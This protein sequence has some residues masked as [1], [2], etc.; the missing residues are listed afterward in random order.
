MKLFTLFLVPF[1]FILNGFS[2]PPLNIAENFDNNNLM[3]DVG[4]SEKADLKIE[5][6]IYTVDHHPAD[7]AGKYYFKNF[8]V[9]D[10][11]DFIIEMNV[12]FVSGNVDNGYGLHWGADGWANSNT[13]VISGNQYYK[14]Q[15][16]E[17]ENRIDDIDW[18][19]DS[20]LIKGKES[21]N[22]IRVEK[23]G[24]Q[25]KI[26]I[27]NTNIGTVKYRPFS[28]SKIG[29]Y[30]SQS[31][32]VE[33]DYLHIYQYGDAKINLVENAINGYQKENLGKSINGEFSDRSPNISSDGKTLYYIKGKYADLKD[34]G[35]DIYVSEQ[36]ENGEW[37]D[38]K[39]LGGPINNEGN[40]SV[41]NVSADGNTLYLLNTYKAD[42]TSNS[43]GLSISKKTENGWEIPKDVII[44]DFYNDSKYVGYS[45]S[46]NRKVMVMSLNR[47]DSYGDEDL[48]VSFMDDSAFSAPLNMGPIIN[49]LNDQSTPFLAPDDKTLYF[50]SNGHPG[51]GS[52]DIFMTR[53]LDDTWTNWSKPENLGPEINS[54]DFDAF[55]TVTA[56]G[57]Y[58]YMVSSSNSFG[59][60]DI[61]KIKVPESAKPTPL[62]L[63]KG[64]VLNSKTKEPIFAEIIYQ[65]LNTGKEVG[66]AL[67]DPATGNYQ[68]VLP[69]GI[70]YG[71]LAEKK[72]FY[73]VSNSADA[74]NIQ[75]YKELNVDLLLTPIEVGENIRLNNLFFETSKSDLKDISISELDRLVLFLKENPAIIIEIGGHTDNVGAAAYNQTLSEKRAQSVMSYLISKEIDAKRL[76]AKGFGLTKPVAPNTND[77]GKAI[78][79]RVEMKILA[80]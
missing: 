43:K 60:E 11:K 30:L 44:D 15:H 55:F 22:L 13:A 51:Y 4:N 10:T 47:K 28:G 7:G 19:K 36:L 27:N 53:R 34:K 33:I 75:E 74:T 18:K 79:R 16:Y 80:K 76:T 69:A 23:T 3:W 21:F 2:Q 45:L 17:G 77:E 38:S 12:R 62:I 6:G 73:P 35:T 8:N 1:L 64:K 67:S 49:T 24:N 61:F 40:N 41:V 71:Y 37:G 29:L 57:D 20:L 68:V 70:N 63:I 25:V 39:N 48:Y 66:K 31:M 65:D 52:Y 58:A 54:T 56:K 72:D 78:N 42:G 50:S 26:S 59:S 14:V 46:S 9:D 32:K 5:N